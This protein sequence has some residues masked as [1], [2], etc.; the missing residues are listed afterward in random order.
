[1]CKV[2]WNV[3]T[4]L[5]DKNIF[6][7]VDVPHGWDKE[8][9]K[10]ETSPCHCSSSA[11]LCCALGP[12]R[13][14]PWDCASDLPALTLGEF[15]QWEAIGW[16]LDMVEKEVRA[17]LSWTL[18]ALALRFWPLH[19]ACF[20]L[21]SGITSASYSPSGLRMPAASCHLWSLVS[22]NP[23]LPQTLPTVL[24]IVLYHSLFKI[25]ATCASSKA[26]PDNK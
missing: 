25:S 13:L 11:I 21:G 4:V 19:H 7:L 5:R 16:E 3:V 20:T 2:Q 8:P 22:D 24:E 14:K 10:N 15:G 6:V 26:L 17:F 18:S 1:M 23:L 9:S 12:G